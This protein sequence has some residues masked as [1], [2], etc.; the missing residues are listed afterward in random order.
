MSKQLPASRGV[1][2]LLGVLRQRHQ[3]AAAAAP[4][5]RPATPAAVQ[6][7]R[8]SWYMRRDVADSLARALDD[9]HFATRQ[10]KHVILAALVEH[11]LADLDA[12]R[13]RL[14]DTP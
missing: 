6:M 10:P 1:D 14:P 2:D 8:R 12:I 5:A 11:A 9:L 13:D 7:D 4:A 3:P